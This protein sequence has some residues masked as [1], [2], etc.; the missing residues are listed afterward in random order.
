MSGERR[1]ALSLRRAP[2]R[3][4]IRLALVL[5]L[6][7][8]LGLTAAASVSVAPPAA[9]AI[10]YATVSVAGASLGGLGVAAPYALSPVFSPTTTDYVR[11]VSGR[12][13]PG[14]PHVDRERGTDHGVDEPAGISGLRHHRRH[15][16]RRDP[17]PGDRD[18][19]AEPR[20]R[21]RYDPVLGA[22][23]PTGL[24]HAP[25][26][27]GRAGI[28]GVDAGLLLHRQHH[29]LQRRVLRHGARRERRPGVVPEAPDGCGGWPINVEPLSNDTIAWTSATG[30]GFGVGDNPSVY[31]G[32]DLETQT[33]IAPL[34]AAVTPTDPH[35]LLPLPN[36]DR[37]MISTPARGEGPLHPRQRPPATAAV[38]PASEANN[39][40]VDCVVQEVNPSNQAVWTWDA[41]P[42]IGLDEVNTA[43]GLPF[44]GPAWGL[45]VSRRRAGG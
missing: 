43:S 34:P 33:T 42:H 13:E 26:Q 17:E 14:L 44:A 31:T 7:A 37:M 40:V 8:G 32:F 2:R 30:L 11:A 28:A 21:S 12:L 36:G 27:P 4:R 23:P 15:L 1:R 22:L 45:F 9:A 35:E 18:L 20:R 24:P 3:A 16:A 38:V 29:E 25:G 6:L 41:A 10:P 39:T 5:C 19:R